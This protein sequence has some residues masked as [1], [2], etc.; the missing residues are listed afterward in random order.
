MLIWGLAYLCASLVAVLQ[1]KGECL[2]EGAG[3]CHGF[4]GES[5]PP[6]DP[7]WRH[8]GTW[9][10]GAYRGG[11]W[12]T[13]EMSAGHLHLPVALSSI[14]IFCKCELCR[15]GTEVFLPKKLHQSC[16]SLQP[17][18]RTLNKIFSGFDK[19]PSP[20]PACS[21][22]GGD[23]N[24]SSTHKCKTALNFKKCIQAVV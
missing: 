2:A 19:H 13:A 7:L 5:L 9:T 24:I 20:A 15:R 18:K 17:G 22:A 12:D 8:F 11:I 14:M 1:K 21:S 6:V 23:T 10:I 16:S 4:I 3:H